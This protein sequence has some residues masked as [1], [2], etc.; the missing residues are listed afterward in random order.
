MLHLPMEPK[1]FAASEHGPMALLT[2]MPNEEI[3]SILEKDLEAF[4]QVVGVNN[5]MGSRFTEDR[6]KIARC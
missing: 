3:Q 6:E 2:R 4:Q 5:H 1:E